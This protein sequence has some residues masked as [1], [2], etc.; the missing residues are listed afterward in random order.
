MSHVT[1]S[2]TKTAKTNIRHRR[3]KDAKLSDMHAVAN[4][5]S[6]EEDG[7]RPSPKQSGGEELDV[8]CLCRFS[9]QQNQET[10]QGSL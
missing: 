1:T 6:V 5:P 2:E 7:V 8:P 9:L 4:S 10:G 3:C